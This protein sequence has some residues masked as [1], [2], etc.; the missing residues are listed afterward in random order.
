MSL[1]TST[2]LEFPT[3]LHILN[4]T[5]ELSSSTRFL[6]TSRQNQS[7]SFRKH[8]TIKM[9][10][11]R[12]TGSLD[13]TEDILDFRTDAKCFDDVCSTLAAKDRALGARAAALDRHETALDARAAALDCPEAA[14]GE[15]EV[16]LMARGRSVS[17][18]E[19]G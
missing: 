14:L 16:A 9:A 18:G 5:I 19:A 6:D 8:A 10:P 3:T 2:E 13:F 12:S 17:A 11:S 7:I 4:R 15:H 1:F